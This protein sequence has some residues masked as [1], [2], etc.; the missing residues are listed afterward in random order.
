M[1]VVGWCPWWV[2]RRLLLTAGAVEGGDRPIPLGGRMAPGIS[3]REVAS[4]C[5]W[6]GSLLA[7]TPTYVRAGG[8]S[9]EWESLEYHYGLRTSTTSTTPTV[10]LHS[11]PLPRSGADGGA[12]RCGS[13]GRDSGRARLRRPSWR[14]TIGRTAGANAAAFLILTLTDWRLGRLAWLRRSPR[15]P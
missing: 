12:V 1:V 11:M 7:A 2:E 3:R 9:W 13:T 15:I 4:T 14:M 10:G 6:W 5:A 8:R